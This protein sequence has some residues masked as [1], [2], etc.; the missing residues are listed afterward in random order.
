MTNEYYRQCVL[1]RGNVT[2]VSY[3]PESIAKQGQVVKLKQTKSADWDEGWR[4]VSVGVRMDWGEVNERS[5]D[6]EHH[7]NAT[8]I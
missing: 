4:V 6:Y 8:D 5:R 7:R 3:I 1:E 2:T